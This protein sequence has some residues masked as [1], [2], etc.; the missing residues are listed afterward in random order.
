MV[1]SRRCIELLCEYTDGKGLWCC[2]L[3]LTDYTPG[4]TGAAYAPEIYDNRLYDV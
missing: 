3:F 4:M 2:I 1:L